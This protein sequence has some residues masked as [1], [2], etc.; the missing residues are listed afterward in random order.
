MVP[1]GH[2]SRIISEVVEQIPMESLI[3]YYAGGGA[4]SYQPKMMIKEWLYGYCEWLY[5]S[6]RMAKALRENIVFIWLAGGQCPCFKTLSEFR[7]ERMQ[8]LKTKSKGR[9][10]VS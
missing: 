7:G 9:V 6:R 3:V 1:A 4:S 10:E 2:L 5:T 8:K